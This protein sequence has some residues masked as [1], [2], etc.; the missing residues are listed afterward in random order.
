MWGS[1]SISC[2]FGYFVHEEVIKLSA[3]RNARGR[4]R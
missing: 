2:E 4:G 1:R 3:K